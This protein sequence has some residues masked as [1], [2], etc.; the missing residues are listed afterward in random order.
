MKTSLPKTPEEFQKAIKETQAELAV[1]RDASWKIAEADLL[2]MME[3]SNFPGDELTRQLYMT[4]LK[5]VW[6]KG[7]QDGASNVSLHVIKEMGGDGLVDMLKMYRD[8]MEIKP[9]NN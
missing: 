8:Q 2:Q 6:N 9:E 1:L 3:D 7:Y 5:G 4:V